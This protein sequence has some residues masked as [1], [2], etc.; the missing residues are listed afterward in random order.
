MQ[1]KTTN[2]IQLGQ[3][4]TLCGLAALADQHGRMQAHD[5]MAYTDM[6]KAQLLDLARYS[7][8][9][10]VRTAAALELNERLDAPMRNWLDSINC[11]GL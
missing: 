7:R 4:L 6:S 8:T 1:T 10:E 11:E 9:D 3:F 2:A 5:S